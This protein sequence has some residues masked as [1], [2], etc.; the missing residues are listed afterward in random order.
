MKTPANELKIGDRILTGSA[1]VRINHIH[2]GESGNI[3]ISHTNGG[4]TYR[5]SDLVYKIPEQPAAISDQEFDD[6]MA[7][8]R[9]Q[10]LIDDIIP[11]EEPLCSYMPSI[12]QDK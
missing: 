10:R 2:V 7:D 8:A 4:K 6:K 9:G 3:L 12:N 11:T 1:I 5:Q